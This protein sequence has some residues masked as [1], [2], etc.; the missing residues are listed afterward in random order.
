MREKKSWNPGFGSAGRRKPATYTG[1]KKAQLQAR[2]NRRWV[3]LATVVGYVLAVSLAAVLLAV[4]YGFFWRPTSSPG[5]LPAGNRTGTKDPNKPGAA[6]NI[7]RK[8]GVKNCNNNCRSDNRENFIHFI[9]R[10]KEDFK[11]DRTSMSVVSAGVSEP[12]AA[13]LGVSSPAWSTAE[14]AAVTAEDPSNLPTHRSA[15][16]RDVAA[17][18]PGT[19]ADFSGSGSEK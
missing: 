16:G 1:E 11:S 13:A 10:K 14:P 8:C 17:G 3:R 19:E 12:P 7:Q 18:S 6:G 5:P 9:D 2:A 4:Y 15:A